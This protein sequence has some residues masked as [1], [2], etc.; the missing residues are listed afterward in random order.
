MVDLPFPDAADKRAERWAA[1]M[2]GHGSDDVVVAHADSA[3]TVGEAAVRT[4]AGREEREDATLATNAT[5]SGGAGSRA[6]D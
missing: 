2:T 6:I 5:R 1:T 4:R 3:A